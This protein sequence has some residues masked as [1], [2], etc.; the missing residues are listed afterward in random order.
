MSLSQPGLFIESRFRRPSGLFCGFGAVVLR[1]LSGGAGHCCGQSPW[2]GGRSGR[3]ALV[4]CYPAF[5]AH[6]DASPMGVSGLRDAVFWPR[7]YGSAQC[8]ASIPGQRACQNGAAAEEIASVIRRPE[9]VSRAPARSTRS[10]SRRR[11][12]P[13]PLALARTRRA[14][15]M[16]C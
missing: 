15:C 6:D 8:S 3:A 12:Q 1:A 10:R 16:T 7:G 13:V 11:L 9:I 5:P 14:M 2:G 4:G